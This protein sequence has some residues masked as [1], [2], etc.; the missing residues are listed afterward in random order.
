[1]SRL[2]P[3][4]SLALVASPSSLTG[5]PVAL[6]QA[7]GMLGPF[8]TYCLNLATAKASHLHLTEG[9]TEALSLAEGHTALAPAVD[10]AYTPFCSRGMPVNAASSA[11]TECTFLALG[12]REG[13]WD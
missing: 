4:W 10:L 7:A 13:S 3:G 12:R 6:R 5:P 11:G 9:E 2:W 1:M 8:P